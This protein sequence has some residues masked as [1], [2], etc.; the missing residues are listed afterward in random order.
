MKKLLVSALLL[1]VCT[2]CVSRVADLTLCSTKNV[3]VRKAHYTSSKR[4]VTGETMREFVFVFPVGRCDVKEAIDR[5]IE[6]APGAVALANVTVEYGW[7]YIPIIYAC[8]WY[9]IEGDP[10]F[11]VESDMNAP[12]PS[13]AS[14]RNR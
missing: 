14:Q 11:E 2:G 8:Q 10:V 1:A 13:R 9:T 7:W 4:R 12:R 6:N 3:D 5:A